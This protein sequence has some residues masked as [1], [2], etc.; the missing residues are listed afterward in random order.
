VIEDS[1]DHLFVNCDRIFPIW[2]HI[3]RWLGRDFVLPNSIGQ[4]F[5][6]FLSLGVG[7]QG[8]LGMLL[9]WHA[10]VW[11]IWTVRNDIIFASGASSVATVVDKVKLSSWKWFLGKNLGSPCSFYEW[12]VEP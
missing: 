8:R 2:Y 10:L 5:E 6:S 9:V 7:R 11:S 3:S 4:V 1:V 12:E